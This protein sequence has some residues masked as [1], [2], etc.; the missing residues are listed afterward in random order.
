MFFCLVTRAVH[1]E[2]CEDL[3]TDCLLM[4]IR[5]FVSRRG[6]LDVIVSDNRRNFVGANQAMKLNFQEEYK[7]D[8]NYMR[9]QLAQKNIQWTFNP[10]LAPFFGRGFGTTYP[11]V[12]TKPTCCARKPPTKLFSLLYS[13][14]G[15]RRSS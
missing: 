15:G 9:L 14:S 1:L 13:C 4:A 7:P 12:Y 8:T 6:Y 10:P 2:V 3:S 11:V 5:R